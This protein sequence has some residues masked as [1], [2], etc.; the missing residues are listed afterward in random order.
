MGQYAD[1]ADGMLAAWYDCVYAVDETGSEKAWQALV[2]E[3]SRETEMITY[4]ERVYR[5]VMNEFAQHSIKRNRNYGVRVTS[6]VEALHRDLKKEIKSARASLLD[7]YGAVSRY[8]GR[9]RSSYEAAYLR[10]CTTVPVRLKK[11]LYRQLLNV[12]STAALVLIEKEVIKVKESRMT[13]TRCDCAFNGQYGLP[14]CHQLKTIIQ[15][16]GQIGLDKVATH[17]YNT[18]ASPSE[19]E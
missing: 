11:D 9:K 19:I 10:D 5:P 8:V 16:G 14:C 2:G 6:R 18:G 1:D 17:W 4:L 3:F 13:S 15:A 7:L 12:I